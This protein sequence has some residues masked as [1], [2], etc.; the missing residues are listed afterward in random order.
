MINAM[1]MRCI[2]QCGGFILYY[3][4]QRLERKERNIRC[5]LKKEE[6]KQKG[7]EE[8]NGMPKVM[9]Y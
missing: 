3:F 8:F 4:L 7:K 5:L 2:Q 6:E 9:S 1:R